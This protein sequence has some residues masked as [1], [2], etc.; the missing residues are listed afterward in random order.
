MTKVKVVITSTKMTTTRIDDLVTALAA[1][2][3]DEA[4][5]HNQTL[6]KRSFTSP[7]DENGS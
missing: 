1:L 3:V 7:T 5:T 4:A 2:P 6:A